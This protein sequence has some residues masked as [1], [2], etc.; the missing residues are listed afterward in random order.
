ME[1][2]ALLW[3]A[4]GAWAQ[5]YSKMLGGQPGVKPGACRGLVMTGATA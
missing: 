2:A 5:F 3:S 1:R 4:P